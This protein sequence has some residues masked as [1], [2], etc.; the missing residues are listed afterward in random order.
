MRAGC[1]EGSVVAGNGIAVVF[2][3]AL[4][5]ALRHLC[6][7]LHKCIALHFSLLNQRELVFPIAG[8]IG[9]R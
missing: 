3:G 8:E 6:N 5:N 1:G 7:F 2:F 9:A 4:H